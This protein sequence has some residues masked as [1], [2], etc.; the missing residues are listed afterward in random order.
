MFTHLHV[1]TEYSLL[2]GKSRIKELVAHAKEMGFQSLAITDHGVM[3]GVISFYK[4]CKEAGIKPIIG[5]EVYV[6]PGSR[7]QKGSSNQA[8]TDASGMNDER[9]HHLILLAKNETG[10]KNLCKICTTGFTEGYYYK[11]RVDEEVLSQH[12]EGLVCLSA[13]I[14]GAIPIRLLKN[15]YEGAKAQALRYQQMFGKENFFIEIQ[16]HDL[17]QERFVLPNLIR[18]A[19]EIGADIVATNDSHYTTQ[20]EAMAHDVLLCMQTGKK[21]SDENRMRFNNDSYYL[22][23]EIEMRQLFPNFSQ[24]CD[25]TQKIADM[26]NF[27]FEFGVIHLPDYETPE[28]Y[29]DNY[30][31]FKELCYRGMKERYGDPL[32][33]ELKGKI[34]YELDI[35]NSM[36]YVNYFLIVWDFINYARENGIPVGPGRG[37]GAGSIAAYALKI[38][39]IDPIKYNLFF[40][41]FLNP[42][43]VSMPDFDIDFCF[44]RRQEVVEYVVNKY[45]TN[46]VSQIIT[47]QTMA[48]RASIK[49]VGR[50]M[51]YPYVETVKIANMIPKELNITIKKALKANAEMKNL[52]DTDE[53]A[54]TLIDMAMQVE[55]MPKSTS[56]HAAGVLICDKDIVEYAP[57]MT[58]EGTMVI[59]STMTELEDLGLLKFDFLGLRTLT[60]IN[61]AEK[62]VRKKDPSFDIRN[63]N[64][65][66]QKVFKNLS[67]GK[68]LG[69]FQ[70][71]SEGMKATLMKLQPHSIE[72]VIALISLYRPGPMDSIPQYIAN[73][74]KKPEEISYYHELIKPVLEPTY[75][76]LVYQEQI[77]K[78]FQIIAGFSLGGSDIVRRAMSK[79]KH[80]VME[81]EMHKFK[82]GYRDE[83]GNLIPDKNGNTIEGAIAKG[84]SEEVCDKLLADMTDF[85]KYAFN[86]SHAACY[87]V[88]AYQTA[89]LITYYP[90]EFYAAYL[91]SFI[92]NNEKLRINI[93]GVKKATGIPMLPPDIN[94]SDVFFTP[95]GDGIRFGLSGLNGIG[96]SITKEL[97]AEREKGPFESLYDFCKR[98]AETK[99]NAKAYES[100][101]KSGAMD[102]FQHTRAT[103]LRYYPSFVSAVKKEREGQAVGQISLF[104]MLGDDERKMAE[105][106][107]TELP[108]MEQSELL[109]GERESAYMYISRHPLENVRK[110]LKGIEV[111]EISDILTSIETQD[112]RYH[113]NM[114]ITIPVILSE[115]EKKI[116]KKGDPMMFLTLSDEA[117]DINGVVFNKSLSQYGHIIDEN[118][119]CLVKG[120]FELRDETPQVLVNS[121]CAFPRSTSEIDAFLKFTEKKK[122]KEP[123][124]QQRQEDVQ[125]D[126]ENPNHYAHGCHM[127]VSNAEDYKKYFR[128]KLLQ[129]PGTYPLFIHLNDEKKTLREQIM[130]N[131]AAPEMKE[132]ISLAGERCVK[133]F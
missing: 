30:T 120:T 78:I 45:G 116:T 52:Y 99:F 53:R 121:L 115:L 44:D 41:R 32:S 108:E 5:C 28:G 132:I 11:P 96:L 79:K 19:N 71:D 110:W 73:K 39:D 114:Q 57:L 70:L 55:G 38:T 75:G 24:A 31:F 48:A 111:D 93:N 82:Y 64:E 29:P 131:V 14:G 102:C 89:Y 106:T 37:S 4:A 101:I 76:C 20:S 125:K 49:D 46:R 1:H 119:C 12:S 113:D 65:E 15:D 129:I 107:M 33:D 17:A 18:I 92:E 126:R 81:K 34:D 36:G 68:M 54:R 40:E 83:N 84:V 98:M 23:S 133:I 3:Y 6:A 60:V 58:A 77:M 112:G 59:Q 105:P 80:S 118:V 27:D 127:L 88:I 67:S 72:D 26:C 10:Y 103:L 66:D 22:K 9:Y 123:P 100:T 42:E 122:K 90:T 104:D 94:K 7:F 8:E 35:I 61:N 69:A 128:E 86:K 16:D 97:I 25:N 62:M 130:V 124:Y 109:A 85:S 13:C 21:V 43:R 47:F 2:D 63:I 74:N 91:T 117:M 87:A 95:E 56:Q 51:E 50:V